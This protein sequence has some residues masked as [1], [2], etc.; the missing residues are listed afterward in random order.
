MSTAPGLRRQPDDPDDH[1]AGLA[2]LL[3]GISWSGLIL[4]WF[5]AMLATLLLVVTD[6]PDVVAGLT[7]G[8]IGALAFLVVPRRPVLLRQTGYERYWERHEAELRELDYHQ[9]RDISDDVDDFLEAQ[10]SAFTDFARQ[11]RR[12]SRR[13]RTSRPRADV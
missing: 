10:S 13:A 9:A 12:K 5:C 2:D 7:F 1:G 11:R 6:A 3:A 8:G 4:L